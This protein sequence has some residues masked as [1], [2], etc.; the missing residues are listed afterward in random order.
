MLDPEREKPP[1]KNGCNIN[2]L[3]NFGT[4]Y[5]LKDLLFVQFSGS[6]DEVAACLFQRTQFVLHHVPYDRQIDT[7]V[8]MNED[9][10]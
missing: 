4:C 9:V 10:A 8:F 6:F 7:K 1:W 3:R 2:L 5:V